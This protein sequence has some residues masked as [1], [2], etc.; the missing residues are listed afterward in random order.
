[1]EIGHES[2]ADLYL[3]R[4]SD[5]YLKSGPKKSHYCAIAAERIPDACDTTV[6]AK[7]N[8]PA[9]SS[10]PGI[11]EKENKGKEMKVKL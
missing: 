10:Q 3:Q 11:N 8:V 2:D 6:A 7:E 5:H 1:M 4:G 9:L